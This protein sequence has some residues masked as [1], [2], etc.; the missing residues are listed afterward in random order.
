MP[1]GRWA[2]T[3]LLAL[4]LT[5]LVLGGWEVYWRG[6]GFTSALVDDNNLWAMTRRTLRSND[7]HQAAL[8][9]A[10]RMQLGIDLPTFQRETGYRPVQL[11]MDGCLCLPILEHLANSS[12]FR[13]LVVCDVWPTAFY[14]RDPAAG[15]A[16]AAIRCYERSTISQIVEE[17]LQLRLHQ[18][19]AFRRPEFSPRQ[20]L[21]AL[22]TRTWPKPAHTRLFADR[23]K[24]GDFTLIKTFDLPAYVRP[25]QPP[26]GDP[27]SKSPEQWR[28]DVTAI[29]SMVA[30]IQGRG[31]QVV[32]FYFPATGGTRQWE[33][34]QWPRY[35]YWDVLATNTTATCIHP[36][37][38]PVL[39]RFLARDGS[40]LDFRDTPAFTREFARILSARLRGEQPPD[41][42][43][44]EAWARCENLARRARVVEQPSW[45]D[46]RD[47]EGV[48]RETPGFDSA[49]SLSRN[50][51]TVTLDL[52][53]PV[54]A[55]LLEMVEYAWR[56]KALSFADF[57]WE[58]SLD[59][60][61]WAEL[62]DTR[63]GGS[64]TAYDLHPSV[65]GFD[66]RGRPP[67]RFLRLTV[68]RAV[69]DD[70]LFL[71]RLLIWSQYPRQDE[72]PRLRR[73]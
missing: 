33:E 23:S 50:P 53:A 7:P 42:V 68:R 4:V 32:F 30:R 72:L 39:G 13:G 1:Q 60:Q 47:F 73:E 26:P 59:G 36:D 69:E 25:E 38:Y 61:A 35:K 11:A 63:R 29:Q 15:A 27:Q 9:G 71:R 64:V 65:T 43:P 45:I 46:G 5:L 67:F 34:E 56:G 18:L 21:K 31:G 52:G 70:R 6:R 14:K 19:F 24:R 48:L 16:A 49:A 62:Y 57:L 54:T 10:S 44:P 22:Q 17:W 8:L 40:H 51:S 37:D 20:L 3:G 41:H 55:A 28:A 2:A 58:T 12:G 66:L